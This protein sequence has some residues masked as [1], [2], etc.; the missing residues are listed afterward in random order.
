MTVPTFSVGLTLWI[1]G[2]AIVCMKLTCLN[3]AQRGYTELETNFP[4]K[5]RILNVAAWKQPMA[6]VNVS[7]HFS[8]DYEIAGFCE[9]KVQI[10]KNSN[11][12]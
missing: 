4:S 12:N 8:V 3:C 7:E 1:V 5:F 9:P 6:S 10:R 11:T 2:K